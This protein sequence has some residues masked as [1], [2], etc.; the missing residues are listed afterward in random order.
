MLRQRGRSVPHRPVAHRAA[1]DDRRAVADERAGIRAA[2][3][4]PIEHDPQGAIVPTHAGLPLL[5]AGAKRIAGQEGLFAVVPLSAGLVVLATFG[6]GRRLGMPRAG[7]VAAC[8]MATC[9]ALTAMSVR[10]MSDVPGAA[11]WTGALYFALGGSA[12]DAI[13]AG[14]CTALAIV[15][16][17]NLAPCAA[18]VLMWY[19]IRD[20]LARRWK[21]QSSALYVIAAL[22]GVLVTAL[23]YRALYGC[24]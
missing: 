15:I 23:I 16:R 4:R 3:Y 11:A 20:D 6:I 8:L 14:L 19:A 5:M 10:P 7:L 18:A 22:P 24:S 2:G 1:V 9:P 17:P 12:L 21:V 13:A